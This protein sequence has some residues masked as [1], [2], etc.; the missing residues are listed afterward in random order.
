MS[1]MMFDSRDVRVLRQ[2]ADAG[3]AVTREQLAVLLSNTDRPLTSRAVRYVVSRWEDHGIVQ[4]PSKKDPEQVIRITSEGLRQLGK[5]E[6]ERATAL[7]SVEA[8]DRQLQT[9]GN[10]RLF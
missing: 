3:G 1:Q 7:E 2:I 10:L 6:K 8:I 9:D 4:R 5:A